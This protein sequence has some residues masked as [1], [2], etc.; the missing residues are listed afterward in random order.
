MGGLA[1]SKLRA[2]L[3]SLYTKYHCPS[4]RAADPVEVVWAYDQL[5]D[6]EIAGLWAAL[7]AWGRRE[8]ALRKVRALLSQWNGAPAMALRE[9]YAL[10]VDWRHRTWTPDDMQTLWQRLRYLYRTEGNLAG[11][12]WKR[13]QDWE[14]AIAEFQMAI[15][16]PPL[17]RYVG[18][19]KK[20]SASKRILLWLRWMI[21]RDCID[22]GPWEGFS[23]A[24]LLAPIDVH[25]RAWAL[26]HGIFIAASPS[27]RDVR[28]LTD[29]FRQISAEDPLRY[30]FSIVTSGSCSTPAL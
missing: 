26:R 29:V 19:L 3:E 12:F 30:D 11:F 14:G 8:V 1:L 16:L 17:S 9:G 7:F 27:W 2:E 21:R 6:Q 25:V 15:G 4:Y 5:E 18:N 23:P 22:P 13:R 28:R 20:G 24:S 10:Q